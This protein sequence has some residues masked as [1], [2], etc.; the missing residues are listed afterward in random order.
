MMNL[1][2]EDIKNSS[3]FLLNLSP[4]LKNKVLKTLAKKINDEKNFILKSNEQDLKNLP[5]HTHSAFIDRL[6]LNQKR[7]KQI[8]E[9]LNFVSK[10][11]DPVHKVVI[12]KKLKNGL[13]LKQ[14]RVPF[15]V[16]LLIFESRP[17][18]AI[19][20]FSIAFKAGNSIIL[21]PG[22][23]SKNTSLAFQSI[24]H[25]V[26]NYYKIPKEVCSFLTNPDRNLLKKILKEKKYIDVVIPRGGE[27]LIKFIEK[28]SKIPLIKNEKGLCH[29]YIEKTANPEMALNIIHNAKTQRPGVCNATETLL[30]DE[31]IANTLLPKIFEKLNI[32]EFYCC[33]KSYKILKTKYP[34]EQDR[35]F[36][37]TQKTFYIEHLSL[38]LNC[39]VVQDTSEAIEFIKEH[40]SKHSECIVTLDSKIAK[41][42]QTQVDAAAVYWNASTRFT[43][44][45][46]FGLGGE[47]GIS[48]QK[49]HVRGP[50]G[51]EA[52]TTLKWVI[53]G[54]GQIRE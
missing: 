52:L 1:N 46:E 21:R 31:E 51:C 32:V 3:Y 47:I 44:G 25:D 38:K 18:V 24:I 22:K 20:A 45:F 50:V 10:I 15:G 29:T 14:V 42:F 43:D 8:I 19:E 23:E 7:L 2:L 39:K 30:I 49:L 6:T 4:T 28:Y 34:N 11:E 36:K 5:P 33:S 35:I 16:I 40:G 27:G 53:D 13:L 17:N 26:L 41:L 54:K 48:T 9:S 37:A 12:Q